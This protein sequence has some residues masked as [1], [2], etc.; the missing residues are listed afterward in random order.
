VDAPAQGG[1]GQRAVAD[2]RIIFATRVPRI[3]DHLARYR[4]ADLFLDTHPYNAHTT[5][6]DAIRAGLPLLTMLGGSF[7]S[8]VA[9]SLLTTLGMPALIAD[10]LEDYEAKALRWAQ[11]PEELAALRREMAMLLPGNA[12]FDSLRQARALETAYQVMVSRYQQGLG[13]G[14]IEVR[15]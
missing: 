13:P 9:A 1:A 3:E 2:S 15:G 8:R 11:H 7:P 14:P 12:L 4:Q 6:N 10:S 5:A